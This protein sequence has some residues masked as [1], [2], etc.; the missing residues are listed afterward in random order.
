MKVFVASTY[1]DLLDYRAA[2]R[3]SILTAGDLLDDMLYWP[4]D[5]SPPLDVSLYHLRSSDLVILLLA[6]RYGTPPSGYDKSITELEFEEALKLRLPVL[7]FHIDPDHPWPPSQMEADPETKARLQKFTYR[8]KSRVTVGTFSTPDSLEVAITHSLTQ[9]VGRRTPKSLPRH[10]EE[11]LFRISRAES[12]YHSANSVIQIGTAPDGMP[13]LLS[14]RRDI[15][16]AEQMAGIITAVGKTV[17]DPV[18][19]GMISQLNQ[20]ARTYAAKSGVYD[21][22]WK[23]QPINVYVPHTTLVDLVSPTLVQSMLGNSSGGIAREMREVLPSGTEG[24]IRSGLDSSDVRPREVVSLGGANRFLCVGLDSSQ[25]TWS[26]GWTNSKPRS[27]VLSRPFIEE[28]LER[29][30][31][32]QYRIKK[33]DNYRNP[34]ILCDTRW[35]QKYADAWVDVLT[36]SDEYDLNGISYEVLVPR[37][38]IVGFILEVI[39]EVAELHDRGQLHGDI[40]PSNMLVNRNGK[41]LID[42]VELSIGEISPTVTVG[43]SPYEQLIRQPLSCAADIYPLGQLL[44]HVIGGQPLGKEVSYRMPGGQKSTVIENPTIYISDDGCIPAAPTRKQWCRLL[45]KAL[46]TDPRDRWPTARA[47]GEDL[48]NLVDRKDVEG[49][50]ALKLPWG[51]RPALIYERQGKVATGW[52]IHNQELTRPW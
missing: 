22:S 6:H 51:D 40:K 36:N 15:P 16:V 12:L 44:I 31:D 49:H 26:G 19:S 3:R 18:Y 33:N 11:R 7:A 45:E 4:A 41:A 34:T 25:L 9:F 39:D 46:R 2:A 14:V 52:V 20:E 32:V 48:R 17:D 35:P 27:L 38:S 10:V 37:S 28:G 42:E 30:S 23:G 43:W 8:V 47:M 24:T 29:L 21:S 50:V 1:Q 5:D 13:L